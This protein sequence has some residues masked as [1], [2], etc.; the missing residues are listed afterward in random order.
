MVAPVNVVLVPLISVGDVN[1]TSVDFCHLVTLPVL[2]LKV[3]FA[4]V[5]PEQM[6]CADATVPPMLAGVTDKVALFEV[7]LFAPEQF[8]R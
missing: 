1:A 7:A 8:V 3:R 4:G 6:V 5:V 2:P